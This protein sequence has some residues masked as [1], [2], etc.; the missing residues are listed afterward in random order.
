MT[1]CYDPMK[2]AIAT[3]TT[4]FG[5]Q[6]PEN[7]LEHNVPLI[8]AARLERPFRSCFLYHEDFA[9]QVH[10]LLLRYATA[11]SYILTPPAERIVTTLATLRNSG[12]YAAEL[13]VP[14]V[15]QG[16]SLHVANIDLVSFRGGIEKTIE[17]LTEKLTIPLKLTEFTKPKHRGDIRHGYYSSESLTKVDSPQKIEITDLKVRQLTKN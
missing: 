9:S 7:R 10:D 2:R 17:F 13:V 14:K 3:F 15:E 1:E 5:K 12:V 11:H 16:I 4:I 8:E 6:L